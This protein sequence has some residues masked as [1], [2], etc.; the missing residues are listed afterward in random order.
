MPPRIIDVR[1][2]EDNRDTVH[3]AVQALAEGWLVGFPTETVYG[4]GASACHAAAVE[5]LAAAKGRSHDSPFALALKGVEEALDYV[6]GMSPLAQ[7]LARRCWPGPVT[8][9]VEVGDR[10]GLVNHLP[11]AVQRFVVPAGWVGLRVPASKI[12]LDVLRM[13]AGPI[14]LTS[15]NKTG[16]ADAVDA[17]GVVAAVGEHL[18]LVLDDG[19]ARYRQPSTVV[20]V[21]DNKYEVLREGVVRESTMERLAS[22]MVVVVCTG[23]TCRSPMAEAFLRRALAD[24]LGCPEAQLD[25]RGVVIASA[26]I[27]AA[28]GAPASPEGVQ[29]MQ[30]KGLDLSRHESQQLTEQL[31]RHADLI[32]TM[33]RGHRQTIVSQWPDAAQRVAVLLPGDRDVADP[34]GAPY[35]AYVMCAEQIEQGIGHHVERIVEEVSR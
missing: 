6:P 22:Y 28:V 11:K 30:K 5:K 7:R 24:R 14:A 8:L 35:D 26:G 21:R 20:R 33:T 3:R 10:P 17:Q 31:V 18:A 4:I 25:S 29:I 1:Q 34:I 23:N 19:P 9:V 32:L 15:A 13:I 27:S 2:A 12:M 16:E